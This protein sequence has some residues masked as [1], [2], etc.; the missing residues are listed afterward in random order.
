VTQLG[1]ARR[2]QILLQSPLCASTAV[3]ERNADVATAA[4]QEGLFLGKYGA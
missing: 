1:G 3:K 2:K 4:R